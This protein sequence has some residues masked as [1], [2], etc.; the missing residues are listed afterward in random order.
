MKVLKVFFRR[1]WSHVAVGLI[2]FSAT[3][4]SYLYHKK[5]MND[6]QRILN[7]IQ[8]SHAHDLDEMKKVIKKEREEYEQNEKKYKEQLQKIEED[9]KKAKQEFEEKKKANVDKIVKKYEGK[10]DEL[11]KK[12]SEVTGFKLVTTKGQE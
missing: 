7:V 1:Y 11:A 5:R 6:Y 9:Y 2:V 3:V 12:M 10:P 4:F 8:D